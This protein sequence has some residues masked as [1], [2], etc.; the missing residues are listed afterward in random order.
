MRHDHMGPPTEYHDY[1]QK[2]QQVDN[3]NKAKQL[4]K[5]Y[6]KE[7]TICPHNKQWSSDNDAEIDQLVELLIAA[8]VEEVTKRLMAACGS[9]IVEQCK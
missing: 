7:A 2:P 9:S 1:T 4:L 6:I 8:A 5:H 3:K